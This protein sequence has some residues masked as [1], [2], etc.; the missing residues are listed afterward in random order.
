MFYYIRGASK[1]T[2]RQGYEGRIYEV[3]P[4]NS[5]NQGWVA[6]SGLRGV[7]DPPGCPNAVERE[8]SGGR[9]ALFALAG[10]EPVDAEREGHTVVVRVRE[11][12]RGWTDL[13]LT[14]DPP[15]GRHYSISFVDGSGQ[16]IAEYAPAPATPLP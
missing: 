12:E 10:F 9:L 11:M 4:G 2:I 5:V 6:T 3:V 15:L 8:G 14:L 1:D 7:I 13:E 16:V